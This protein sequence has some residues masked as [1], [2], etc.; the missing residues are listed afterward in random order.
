[1][2][3]LGGLKT[4][5][6]NDFHGGTVRVQGDPPPDPFELAEVGN[7][8]RLIAV[9]VDQLLAGRAAHGRPQVR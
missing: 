2:S 1:L 6:C 9:M 3:D 8:A 7:D 4:L 5:N